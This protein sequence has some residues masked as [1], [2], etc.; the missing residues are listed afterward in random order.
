ML[1]AGRTAR[2]WLSPN[3]QAVL[4]SVFEKEAFQAYVRSVDD[5]G[6]WV[7]GGRKEQRL[8]ATGSVLL[9]RWEYLATVQVE[10]PVQTG[11]GTGQQ[12]QVH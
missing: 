6:I 3:G 10:L 9:L 11:A 2:F 5:L 4:K 8:Q 7:V 12:E 1:L